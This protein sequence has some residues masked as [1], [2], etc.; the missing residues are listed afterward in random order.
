VSLSTP[1]AKLKSFLL[2]ACPVRARRYGSIAL[3]GSGII[4]SLAFFP[5]M[6]LPSPAE[7]PGEY[8]VI[9][10]PLPSHEE[11][12]LEAP[13][14][15]AMEPESPANAWQVITIKRNDTLGT[16]FVKAGLREQDAYRLTATSKRAKQLAKQLRPGR[17]VHLLADEQ[18]QLQQL[19][20]V[21]NKLHYTEF[22][23][24]DAGQYQ[25][26][27]VV[28]TPDVLYA[29][30]QATIDTSLFASAN[31]AGI[32]DRLTM[33][34]AD[35]FGWDIDFAMDIRSGDS[36]HMVYEELYLNGEKIADGEIVAAEFRNRGKN[37][38]A[39]R[40]TD[41]IGETSYYTPEGDSMR[42]AF[43]RSPIEFARISSHFNLKRKHPILHTIRAH[44]GTD[45][46]AARGTPIRAT[47]DGRIS[48]AGTQG[49]Y[50]R[51]VIIQHGSSYETLYSHL[52][53]YAK[54]IKN[55]SRVKQ[56]QVIGY[57]GSSGLATG[58]HLHY[59][60]HVNGIQRNPVT[61]K[62][63]LTASIS[64]EEKPRFLAISSR[65]MLQLASY[66]G[67]PTSTQ[68]ALLDE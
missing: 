2:P 8:R 10:L 22:V 25:A 36:F 61:I 23:R 14:P 30:A 35:V 20:F 52:Q 3:L 37:F 50:G 44:K 58:P 15:P 33:K 46:A 34:L 43:L 41:S 53:N 28:L 13:I 16:L 24:D 17:E 62:F 6:E 21:E 40:Y 9:Q 65:H 51:T 26:Q 18:K 7:N 5:P 19:R 1:L 38:Q 54:G 67:R 59:E 66:L 11:A 27:D 4:T 39:V 60:F 45:Y 29:F 63:P 55:G 68:L 32:E 47:G 49:G 56:G 57:V 64:A 31:E 42:K 12:I 48:F